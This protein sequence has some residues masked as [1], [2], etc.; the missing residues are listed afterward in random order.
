[1]HTSG[2][3]LGTQLDRGSIDR[4]A[5]R[6]KACVLPAARLPAA[7][8]Q[9]PAADRHYEAA[10]LGDRNEMTGRDQAALRM[11]PADE[12]LRAHDRTRLEIDLRLVVQHELL[13]LQGVTQAGLEGLPLE[14]ADIHLG[15][16]ELVVIAATVLGVEHREIRVLH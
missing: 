13:L 10:L 2:E 3:I 6:R 1:M 7:F 16:E 15:L 4:N 5:Q 12:G 9:N 14:C 11:T 8:A